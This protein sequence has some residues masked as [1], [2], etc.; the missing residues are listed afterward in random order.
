MN[1]GGHHDGQVTAA[2]QFPFVQFANPG[3]RPTVDSSTGLG[4]KW[5]ET[6][7]VRSRVDRVRETPRER[8]FVGHGGRDTSRLQDDDMIRPASQR[9]PDP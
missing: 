2:R 3:D 6:G 7:Q 8:K 9:V 4:T 1:A 5:K